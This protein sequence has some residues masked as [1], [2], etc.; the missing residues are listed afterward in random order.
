MTEAGI[1]FLIDTAVDAS[2]TV[3]LDNDT[4]YILYLDGVNA[5]TTKSNLSG[6]V[7]LSVGRG[8]TD[9]KIVKA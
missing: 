8:E 6:K 7:M 5:G 1:D 2:I 9:V 4:E 3:G